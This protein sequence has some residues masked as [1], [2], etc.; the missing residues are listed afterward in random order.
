[1]AATTLADDLSSSVAKYREPTNPSSFQ[2]SNI[3]QRLA[4]SGKKSEVP[5]APH[6]AQI[7]SRS[8]G[9]WI[10]PERKPRSFKA[11]NHRDTG[12]ECANLVAFLMAVTHSKTVMEPEP[13]STIPGP[14]RTESKCAPTTSVSTPFEGV[15]ACHLQRRLKVST[16]DTSEDVMSDRASRL[17]S[18]PERVPGKRNILQKG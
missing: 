15:C 16:V 8:C 5:S 7:I 13:L 18:C 17:R 10:W 6:Q 1:M 4:E 14:V 3:D 12:P 11:A 9:S 2:T